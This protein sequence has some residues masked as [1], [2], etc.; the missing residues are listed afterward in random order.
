MILKLLRRGIFAL[1]AIIV[2]YQ[3]WLFAHVWWWVDHN[4]ANSAFMDERL[5]IL[6]QKNTGCAAPFQMG[7]L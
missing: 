2:L 7:A 4:P 1:L 6:Q 5:N 3:F